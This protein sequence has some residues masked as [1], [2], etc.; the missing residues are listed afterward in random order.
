MSYKRLCSGITNKLPAGSAFKR[1]GAPGSHL[2]QVVH[3]CKGYQYP[4]SNSS[5]LSSLCLVYLVLV[6]LVRMLIAMAHVYSLVEMQTHSSARR[7]CMSLDLVRAWPE[8]LE[9]RNKACW[10]GSAMAEDMLTQFKQQ[11][12]SRYKPVCVQPEGLN[13]L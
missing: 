7:W 6:S 5:V 3:R 1:E 8:Q 10:C 12:A 13:T 4:R 2:H 9:Y 11:T